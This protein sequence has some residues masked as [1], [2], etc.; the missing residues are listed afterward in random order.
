MARA[1]YVRRPVHR[2][3]RYVY[4]ARKYLGA[5]GSQQHAVAGL[6]ASEHGDPAVDLRDIGVREDLE[7]DERQHAADDDAL[8]D[9]RDDVP[10]PQEGGPSGACHCLLRATG[11]ICICHISITGHCLSLS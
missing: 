4:R 1:I 5:R 6:A 7:R 8:H 2:L 3:L 10:P 9:V 11:L